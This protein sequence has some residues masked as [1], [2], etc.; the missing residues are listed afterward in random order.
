MTIH[1]RLCEGEARGNPYELDSGPNVGTASF[2]GMTA[3]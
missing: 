2:A 1:R 3:Y